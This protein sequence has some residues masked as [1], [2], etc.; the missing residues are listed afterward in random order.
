MRGSSHSPILCS[1]DLLA[2]ATEHP[3]PTLLDE[4]E[5]D[6]LYAVEL[7]LGK[8][9]GVVG[10]CLVSKQQVRWLM[11]LAHSRVNW[12]LFIDGKYRVHGGGW[13]LITVGTV[14][15]ERN[16]ALVRTA[17]SDASQ[18]SHPSLT[19]SHNHHINVSHTSHPS[20]SMSHNH[21]IHVSPTSL[22]ASH[23][24]LASHSSA[25]TSVVA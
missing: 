23:S 13:P 25:C 7:D 10:V 14:S 24:H 4:M 9:E 8:Y 20:L 18:T 5:E 12:P 15:L 16:R 6:K 2:W 1:L 21:H 19:I 22:V 17:R 3:L 11:Q